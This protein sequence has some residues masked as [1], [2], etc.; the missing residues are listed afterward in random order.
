MT[1]PNDLQKQFSAFLTTTLEKYR[2]Q[3]S[4]N[5]FR[6]N[7][8]LNELLDNGNIM[9]QD[10]GSEIIQPLLYGK[11]TTVQSYQDYE[12]LK[13]EPQD[14]ITAAEFDWKQIAGTVMISRAERRKNSG[15]EQLMNLFDKKVQQAEMTI[16][17]EV[18]NQLINA[19][20]AGN[21]GKDLTPI[22]KF[23]QKDPSTDET[24]GDIN[25]KDHDWWRNQEASSS[26]TTAKEFKAELY[27]LYNACTRG[28]TRSKPDLAIMDQATFEEYELALDEQKRYQDEDMADMG[29]E[30]L[31]LKGAR[32]VWD[33]VV[34]DVQNQTAFD[35][36]SAYDEGSN[37]ST[38]SV[39]FV[40]T[41]FLEFFIDSQTEF[42][43]TD[44]EKPVNQ[45]AFVSQIL[46]MGELT[47]SNR[48]KHGV[49]YDIN[50]DL[51]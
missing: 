37:P 47:V 21:Q 48:Q 36:D 8:I 7:V 12:E 1:S 2:D 18:N 49:L 41:D 22:P 35:V 16:K 14:G 23:I 50:R 5:I 27:S 3:L 24:V 33:E 6:S 26:A 46:F 4:D 19:F 17:E 40:T 15:E 44:F 43:S 20:S 13:T 39:F 32:A 51:S 34:P 11:N 38:G 25:Q 42:V 29:F 31:R 28:A 9:R 10:G 30:N 45:D